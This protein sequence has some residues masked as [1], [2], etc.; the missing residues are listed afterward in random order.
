MCIYRE[1]EREKIREREREEENVRQKG[2]E[3]KRVPVAGKMI[4]W[5]L[6]EV[7]Q[8]SIFCTGGL[9]FLYNAKR[10]LR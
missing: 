6:F 4:K 10:N 5:R 1:R 3:E 2:R 9:F 7:K 8:V